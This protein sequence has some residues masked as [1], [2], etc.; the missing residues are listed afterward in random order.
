MGGAW[1]DNQDCYHLCFAG[2]FCGTIQRKGILGI[3]NPS[4]VPQ[5]ESPSS[6]LGGLSSLASLAGFDMDMS[7][8]SNEISPY[9]IL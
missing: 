1:Y 2:I 7:G 6:K 9:Y 4:M 5:I 3:Y 8:G